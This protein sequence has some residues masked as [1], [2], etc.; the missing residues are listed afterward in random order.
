MVM[1]L[2]ASA[3]RARQASRQALAADDFA[4]LYD[5]ASQSQQVCYT[6]AGKNLAE[7]G[8]WL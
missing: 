5:L 8:A 1:T 3:W 7:L 6:Q 4:R 2:A